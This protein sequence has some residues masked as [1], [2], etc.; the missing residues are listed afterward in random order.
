MTEGT[1]DV[2]AQALLDLWFGNDE[3]PVRTSAAKASLWWGKDPET[4]A[5]LAARFGELRERAKRGDLDDWKRTARG[6]LALV[7]ALD[8]L[9]RNL[10]RGTPEA[11]AADPKALALALE[12]I[13]Q[14]QDAELGPLERTFL[15]MPL[16]HAEDAS[17]QKRCVELFQS[18]CDSVPP[19]QREVFSGSVRF[20]EAHRDIVV[21][22][23]RFPH[24]N[25]IL[26]RT[27]TAEEMEFLTQPNSSF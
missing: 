21:R 14:G 6:R 8:Q 26:G 15:Y 3:D 24:R 13:D 10:H 20:A 17:I 18:L 4:D 5:L 1:L 27:S 19:E 12:G 23:R 9:S 25:S 22:F 2:A 7:I 11:F 16:M